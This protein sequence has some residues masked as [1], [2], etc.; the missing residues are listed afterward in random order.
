MILVLV[1][2]GAYAYRE[3]I[4]DVLVAF[5]FGFVGYYLK[6]YGWPRIPLVIGLVL[7]SLFETNFHL[8]L[9][10]QA[11]ER[12]D[13][14][15]RPVV[16]ILFG[17][18]IMSVV[19]SLRPARKSVEKQVPRAPLKRPGGAVLTLLL[20]GFVGVLAYRT[21]GFGRVAAYVPQLVL[22]LLAPLLLIQ[23]CLDHLPWFAKKLESSEAARWSAGK[24]LFKRVLA[25]R[26]EPG[27]T[28][29]VGREWGAFGR[30][31]VLPLAVYLLNLAK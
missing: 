11:L 9:R 19:I 7:G 24:D 29:S 27:G 26:G 5:V 22:V 10:L 14:W 1:T 23:T 12:I 15:S 31:L 13:F 4:E 30:L 20:L 8:T 25:L 17:L 6:K 28:V 16:L 21:L 2:L 3:R 18:T